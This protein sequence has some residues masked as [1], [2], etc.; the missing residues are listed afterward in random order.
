[1]FIIHIIQHTLFLR[2]YVT[3]A[4]NS[5]AWAALVLMDETFW[6][7][8]QYFSHR[9]NRLMSLLYWRNFL[10]LI[11][12]RLHFRYPAIR[13]GLL[14][15]FNFV[16]DQTNL[17]HSANTTRHQSYDEVLRT[18][19]RWWYFP[20]KLYWSR[21]CC[22]SSVSST[23]VHH[24][25]SPFC[26]LNVT[27]FPTYTEFVPIAD[28]IRELNIYLRKIRM[29]LLVYSKSVGYSAR[30]LYHLNSALYAHISTGMTRISLI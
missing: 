2:Q 20:L 15:V 8:L 5:D 17:E 4:L 7:I 24:V 1:L 12:P 18:R 16:I 25:R 6:T 21:T 27:T 3:F 26:S 28:N 23:D 10:Y 9:R 14:K 30:C 22:S 13:Y 19:K 29:S 11:K